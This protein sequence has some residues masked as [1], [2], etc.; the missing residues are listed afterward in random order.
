VRWDR[1]SPAFSPARAFDVAVASR[2][3]SDALGP[4]ARA[5]GPKVVAKWLQDAIKADTIILALPLWEHREVAKALASWQGK[6]VID[7][8]NAFGVPIEDLD[9][10]LSSTVVAKAFVDAKFVKGFNYLPCRA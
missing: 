4:Q 10:L 7:A 5:I 9:G 1:P 2:Q 6:T 3:L 8:T